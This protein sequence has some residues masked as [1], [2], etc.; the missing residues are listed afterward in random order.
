MS[1]K[2]I[3]EAKE[4]TKTVVKSI[5]LTEKSAKTLEELAL[6]GE[7]SQNEIINILLEENNADLEILKQIEEFIE[8]PNKGMLVL[9]KKIKVISEI[10]LISYAL[11][12]KDDSVNC[13]IFINRRFLPNADEEKYENIYEN[14]LPI[15]NVSDLLNLGIDSSYVVQAK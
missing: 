5:R 7:T 9:T 4:N 12:K 3:I 10:L 11:S 2:K 6:K 15:K 14:E 8:Y 1:I 13:K